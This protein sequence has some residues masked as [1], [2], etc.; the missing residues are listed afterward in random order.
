MSEGPETPPRF[1]ARIT[2]RNCGQRPRIV[3][4]EPLPEDFTLLPQEELEIVAWHPSKVPSFDMLEYDGPTDS[5]TQVYP[6][7]VDT[8]HY[9]VTQN[10][11]KL[12]SGHNRQA[13]LDAGLEM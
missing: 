6:E 10:G 9:E 12:A 5:A 8:D 4:V 1:S 11:V 3:W 7:I 13:A 2:I